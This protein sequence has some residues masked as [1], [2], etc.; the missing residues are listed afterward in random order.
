MSLEVLHPPNYNGWSWGEKKYTDIQ[1]LLP[2]L[3]LLYDICLFLNIYSLWWALLIV[4]MSLHSIV[5]LWNYWQWL[6]RAQDQNVTY[7]FFCIFM[8]HNQTN[9]LKHT[10]D[11]TI[12]WT[13]D[14]DS[15]NKN[16][17]MTQINNI[18]VVFYW[19]CHQPEPRNAQD[20]CL[21]HNSHA[22]SV[23]IFIDDRLLFLRQQRMYTH[24]IQT[25]WLS[26]FS[27]T[28]G[29]VLMIWWWVEMHIYPSLI[30]IRF[31]TGKKTNLLPVTYP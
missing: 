3:L 19:N 17:L 14:I 13:Q 4:L 12:I 29:C 23:A 22:S 25:L 21:V 8:W 5:K 30:E 2:L 11:N 15:I 27:P 1:R 9:S 31:D 16:M 24:V 28:G 10:W 20:A 6:T 7:L 18:V 26:V